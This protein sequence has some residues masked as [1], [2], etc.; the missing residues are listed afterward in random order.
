MASLFWCSCQLKWRPPSKKMLDRTFTD[1]EAVGSHINLDLCPL[2]TRDSEA[3]RIQHVGR[4][5]YG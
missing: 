2:V 5:Q 1:K 3:K 4:N